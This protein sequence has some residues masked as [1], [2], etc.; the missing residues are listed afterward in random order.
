[1]TI[2]DVLTAR[3]KWVREELD[4]TITTEQSTNFQWLLQHLISINEG[5]FIEDFIHTK[6]SEI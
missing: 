6:E 3:I 4:K 2:Q 1:M 5:K